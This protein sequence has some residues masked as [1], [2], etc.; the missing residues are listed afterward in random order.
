MREHG[1]EAQG[2]GETLRLALWLFAAGVLPVWALL[3]ATVAQVHPDLRGVA[4]QIEPGVVEV[5]PL[6]MVARLT[7]AAVI[8]GFWLGALALVG[9]PLAALGWALQRRR[10]PAPVPAADLLGDELV[11][12]ATW[13]V[14]VRRDG[15]AVDEAAT[16]E[17]VGEAEETWMGE[18]PTAAAPHTYDD[19]DDDVDDLFDPT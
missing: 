6:P 11:R 17:P 8:S 16:P 9:G 12:G 18:V 7:G 10:T 15:E 5:V 2:V 19:G 13:D 14:R 1:A 4:V 3:T